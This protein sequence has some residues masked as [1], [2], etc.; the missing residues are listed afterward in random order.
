MNTLDVVAKQ[1]RFA[2]SPT[3]LQAFGVYM[4]E[5]IKESPR[6]GLTSLGDRQ[7]IERR[8]F[9]ESLALLRAL[10]GAGAFA[11]PAIDIG[12]GAG[13]PSLPWKVVRPDLQ[14]T[15]LEASA[16][17]VNFLSQVIQELDLHDVVAIQAR[18]E[19][20]ARDPLHREKY[21][22]A[23]ARAVAPLRVLVEL[24]LPFLEAGGHLA[25]PKGSSTP[26]EVR[27]A[28]AALEVCGGEVVLV[29]KLNLPWAGPSP[30]LVLVRKI[31]DTPDR[32]PR[33][34]GVPSK[35]PL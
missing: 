12:A 15:L 34:A 8:H 11:S 4:R 26:R 9:G 19:E 17:K 18:A 31:S 6:A 29:R 20:L 14:L 28:A 24:S 33:R 13:F 27:E 25:T 35:R 2:L 32:Y 3:Q 21:A 1:L 5:L 10:E 22:L 16:R 7:S 23:L 30:T